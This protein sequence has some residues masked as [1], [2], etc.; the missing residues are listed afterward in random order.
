MIKSL[1]LTFLAG[2]FI[3]FGGMFVLLFKNKDRIHSFSIGLSIGVLLLLLILDLVPESY[4]LLNAS[5]N[6]TGSIVLLILISILGILLVRLLDHF[7]PEHHGEHK[8][9]H[10]AQMT[11]IALFIHNVVEGMALYATCMAD[12]KMGLMLVIGI[13]MHNFAL[14]LSISSELLTHEKNKKHLFNTLLFLTISTF[15][16]GV[17]MSLFN[18]Y[19]ETSL[20]LAIIITLTVGMI[21]YI[22]FFELIP[23]FINIKKK[24]NATIGLI[25]GIIL[26]LLTLLFE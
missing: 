10:V 4:E 16:G 7:M 11:G 2:L 26:M 8:T 24:K 5:F 12:I 19:L 1:L 25:V 20:T 18:V 13:A 22:V 9:T 6:K 3:L 17:V 23:H 15:I 21:V 14:G